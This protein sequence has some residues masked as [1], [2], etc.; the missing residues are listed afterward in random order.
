MLLISG[1]L[2]YKT[3]G[4]SSRLISS[5]RPI[6]MVNADVVSSFSLN[7]AIFT[8][9][10]GRVLE[11]PVTGWKSSHYGGY[12]SLLVGLTS[13]YSRYTKILKAP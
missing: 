11:V 6:I 1:R 9:S 8:I 13:I 12:Y 4:I 5:T 2:I 10:G 7:L 3:F